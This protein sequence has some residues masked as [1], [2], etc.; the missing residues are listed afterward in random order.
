[1][2]LSSTGACAGC[3]ESDASLY[4]DT[5]RE[6]AKGDMFPYCRKPDFVRSVPLGP[7][8][9]A[10][11]IKVTDGN[12]VDGWAYFNQDDNVEY[13]DVQISAPASQHALASAVLNQ[14]V[15]PRKSKK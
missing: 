6:S 8:Q 9:R 4:F 15:I 13:Y 14:F 2:Y 10:Y 5:V 11:S 1:M 12:P 7:D 3:A